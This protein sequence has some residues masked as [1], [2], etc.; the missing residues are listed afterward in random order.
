MQTEKIN[1]RELIKSLKQMPKTIHI[2]MKVDKVSFITIVILHIITGI[3]PIITLFLSQEFINAI[4]VNMAFKDTIKIF[5]IYIV[6][7]F[8]SEMIDQLQNYIQSRYQNL[9]QYRLQYFVMEECTKMSLSDFES[10]QMYDRIEKITGEVSFQPYQMFSS[11][12]GMITAII[13]MLSAIVY[14]WM[15]NVFATIILIVVPVFSMIFYLKIGKQEFEMMWRRASEERKIWYFSHLLTRDFSFKE[16]LVLG[17]KDYFLNKHRYITNHFLEE[18]MKN[19][20]RK[21]A[22][23]ILYDIVVSSIGYV[24]IGVAVFSAYIGKI[25]A[26]NVVSC[27]RSIGM[28]QSNSQVV[29]QNIYGIYSC[30]LYMNMLFDF[31][32]YSGANREWSPAMKVDC[33]E[34]IRMEDVSF[35]YDGEHN[36][37]DHIR[38]DIK[39]GEK[40]A[41]VGPNG[42]GKSSLLKVIAG[43]YKLK[44][45]TIYVNSLNRDDIDTKSYYNQLSILFQDYVKYELSLKEN[46]GFGC[47][48]DIQNEKKMKDILERLSLQALKGEDGKYDLD[49]QLGNWFGNGRQLSQGQWQKVALA[50][51]YFKDAS[52]Y[53]LDEPNAALDTVSEKEVFQSFFKLCEKKIGVYISHRLNAAQMADRIIVMDHG[54]IVAEGKHETLMKTCEI[55]QK[56]YQAE[57]YEREKIE[58]AK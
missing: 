22:F 17:L 41:L 14:L 44:E 51:T 39:K 11:I 27:I 49:M 15:W 5:A 50:R 19:L 26:G 30:T 56:L 10:S 48:S 20:K 16:V 53:I 37:L 42:S 28:I 43:L 3:I 24:I 46:I 21:T 18:N 36:V 52:V 38:L 45:G 54:K 4:I 1:F 58:Y 6:A 31:L 7:C 35:S 29:M 40:I 55:Y 57:T 13:T 12:I 25:L 33:I 2:L 47:I 34:E 23:Q 8:V 9:L 32:A